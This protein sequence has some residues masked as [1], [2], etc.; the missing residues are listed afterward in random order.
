MRMSIKYKFIIGFLV[1]FYIGY[2]A[3]SFFMN[4]LIVENNKDIIKKE[5][6]TFEKDL[7]VYMK[8]YFQLK[9]VDMDYNNFNNY[10]KDIASS[11]SLKVESRVILYSYE[12]KFLVDSANSNGQVLNYE[13]IDNK[14]SY[15]NEDL[16][17]SMDNK[18]AFTIVPVKDKYLVVF[19]CPIT[20][21]KKNI[22]IIRCIMD[23]SEIFSSSRKLLKMTNTFMLLV[24]GGIFL[25]VILLSTKIT[26]PILNLNKII[27]EVAQGNFEEDINISSKDEIEE[28]SLNFNKMKKQIKSQIETI[29]KD[30]DNLKKLSS[31]RK[32]FFDNMTHE[33]KTPLTIIS[34]YS[35]IL[36][37]QDFKDIE[38]ARKSLKKISDESERMHSMVIELLEISKVE[39]NIASKINEE[40][41]I[42]Q[43]VDSACN[44][45]KIRADKYEVSIVKDID[46]EVTIL[47]NSNELRRVIVN[48]ID[49]S[50]K[51][52][53]IK[54]TI[55]VK[56]FR[57]D[58]NCHIIIKDMGQGIPSDK[59]KMIFEP[60]YRVNKQVSREEG[61][62]GLGLSI[63]KKIID[64]HNGNIKIISEEGVGTEVHVI[65]PLKVYNIVTPC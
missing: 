7:N 5:L 65:I 10:S 6:L 3:M 25:F 50:I 37:K 45:M 58:N 40:I 55:E 35:Q 41:N 36:I 23:Y 64:K 44:D 28:V 31:H 16:K 12:G 24:F 22:G 63:V 61:S 34:G 56:V 8:Q 43:I 53:N 60:F 14:K 59:L 57:E 49:N 47:G 18:S 46:M 15:N 13:D 2:N 54:S 26:I 38:F 29:K 1:I 52:G 4:K 21:N 9:N 32:I 62:S 17:M 19:S 20:E 51:Y 39:S 42:S 11:L 27:K 30:R 48:I 33:M